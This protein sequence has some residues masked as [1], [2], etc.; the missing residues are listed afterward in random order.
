MDIEWLTA[1]MI[2]GRDDRI[3]LPL[4]VVDIEIDVAWGE[5][6]EDTYDPDKE[7]LEDREV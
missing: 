5:W 7:R 4:P 6:L 2:S 3:A 1:L